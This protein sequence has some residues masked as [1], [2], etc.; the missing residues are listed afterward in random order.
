[1]PDT[2]RAGQRLAERLLLLVLLAT[3]LLVFRDYGMTWDEPV[4]SQYG[5]LTLSYFASGLRDTRGNAFFDLS[6]YGPLFE[7][8]AAAVYV[9]AGGAK[10]EIRHLLIALCGLA[11]VLGVLRYGRGLR[12]AWLPLLAALALA[13]WPRFAGHAFNNSKDIPFACAFTWAMVA[14]ARHVDHGRRAAPGDALLTG[15]AIGLALAVRVGGVLLF[16]FLALGGLLAWAAA[17]APRP[18]ARDLARAALAG[19]LV[20]GVAWGL[21]VALW[22]AAHEAPLRHPLQALAQAARF[23]VAH[24][25]VFEGKTLRGDA[26]PRYY[27]P[28]YLLITT[29][30]PHLA[31]LLL[32]IGLAL[33]GGP[34]GWLLLLWLGLPIAGVVA[35]RPVLYDEIRHFLF[36]IPA[37][38]LLAG[39]GAAWLLE[40]LRSR[41]MALAAA[42]PLLLLFPLVE[43]WRLHPYEATYF[44]E[45]VGGLRGA[46]RDYDT[47]YWGSSNKEAME[48]IRRQPRPATGPTRVLL[49][50]NAFTRACADAYAGP[51]IGTATVIETGGGPVLPEGFDY[52]VGV[53]RLGL[54]E[55]FPEAPI[56]HTVGREDAVF[57]VIKGRR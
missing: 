14:I 34:R 23:P 32:G 22:P 52:Y 51:G 56:V 50:A 40:R 10:A 45:L 16:A 4:Q 47:D 9:T 53:T 11:A 17:R 35:T 38:A 43:S 3:A 29:P 2:P 37:A 26:L 48:W 54:A 5:E 15:V 20:L 44:N 12:R 39:L 18:G 1:M 46:A 7:A 8:V 21:M 57:A 49:G 33:R 55:L 42:V 27:L 41:S 28:K 36:L 19:L 25:V 13:T 31:F 30:L 6:Y 24:E